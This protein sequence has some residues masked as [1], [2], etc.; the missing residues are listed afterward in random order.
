MNDSQKAFVN[1]LSQALNFINLQGVP[2][3]LII[4]VAAVESGWGKSALSVNDNN[5][6]GIKAVGNQPA[7]NY[8]TR[9][10]ING[11][12]I[13]QDAKFRRY[14]SIKESIEDYV[15]LLNRPRYKA[16]L[17]QPN[18]LE[19][20]KAIQKAGYSTAPNYADYIYSIVTKLNTV[21]PGQNNLFVG[22]ILLLLYLGAQK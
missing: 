19:M 4:A 14:Q 9:E 8:P 15:R 17:S 3:K 7:T 16:A 20:L 12:F 10:Y 21:E 6:F 13:I 1:K 22:I 11:R 2:K 18:I 5:L